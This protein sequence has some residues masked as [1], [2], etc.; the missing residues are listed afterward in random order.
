MDCQSHAKITGRDKPKE[1]IARA[2]CHSPWQRKDQWLRKL[3]WGAGG[4]TSPKDLNVEQEAEF[5]P[6]H[7][8]Y[9]G[10]Y[11]NADRLYGRCK[12]NHFLMRL[13][14]A[15]K[16]HVKKDANIWESWSFPSFKFCIFKGLSELQYLGWRQDKWHQTNLRTWECFLGY[17]QVEN[18][19]LAVHIQTA[20]ESTLAIYMQHAFI[21]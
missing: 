21:E 16:H 14:S 12:F 6:G 8:N 10:L 1:N 19:C 9:T 15:S 20:M 11:Q 3:F 13:A 17:V 18:I 5:L 7:K 2:R 4:L